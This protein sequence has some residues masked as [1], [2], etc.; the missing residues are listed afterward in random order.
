MLRSESLT[1]LNGITTRQRNQYGHFPV[2]KAG[3]AVHAA[4]GEYMASWYKLLVF[5]PLACFLAAAQTVVSVN[6]GVVNYFEGS[7]LID[8]AKLEQK[9]GTFPMLHIGS[10]LKT[11]EGRAE[12]LLTPGIVL[13]LD[14]HSSIRMLTNLL[15][16]TKIEF[17]E[18]S[19]IL[20]SSGAESVKNL[21]V[22]YRTSEIRFTQPGA[23]RIDAEPAMLRVYS[24]GTEI[25]NQSNKTAIDSSHLFFFDA[26]LDTPNY[27]ND[28]D[29]EF[30]QWAQDRNG[31]ITA[32]NRLGD[33]VK[34]FGDGVSATGD[35]LDENGLAP[36]LPGVGSV[37]ATYVD[38]ARSPLLFGTQP[39][40]NSLY[41]GIGY[42]GL[43]TS[44]L[45]FY[46]SAALPLYRWPRRPY[47]GSSLTMANRILERQL[48]E[49]RLWQSRRSHLPMGAFGIGRPYAPT[50]LGA[51][52]FTPRPIPRPITPVVPHPAFSGGARPIGVHPMGR[53]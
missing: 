27:G 3:N 38:P 39:Y 40:G 11:E 30:Y 32:D 10:I 37:D 18:G 4:G 34:D 23:Y 45:G 7:V 43:G 1:V 53:R 13:R 9:F 49:N 16:D 41:G 47:V 5:L 51:R 14:H 29:D 12:V 21:L 31:A 48:L 17:L 8:N 46:P 36:L 15:T 19:A 6:S 22:K 28:N 25:A 24:G 33:Q 50:Y 52:P 35:G 42:G 20:D 44:S 2:D 26:G